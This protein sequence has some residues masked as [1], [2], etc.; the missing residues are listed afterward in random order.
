MNRSEQIDALSAALAKAQGEMEAAAKD[1]ENPYFHSNYA[2]LASV[3]AAIRKPLSANG[4]AVIQ[5][6]A[7]EGAKVTVTTI[8]VHS[9]GQW[10]SSDLTMTSKRQLKDGGGWETIDNPQAI[11]STVKYARR[12]ALESMVGVAA[13]D[14]DGEG[15]EGREPGQSDKPP[16]RRGPRA[17]HPPAETLPGCINEAQ[18]K[19][20]FALMHGAGRSQ[21]GVKA[22][23]AKHGFERTE[24]ITREKYDAICA[25]IQ[26]GN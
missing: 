20:I 21:A 5:P 11:G 25:E 19:R 16:A 13:E 23:I 4:L 7:V 14:D 22:I 24:Q 6:V 18:Q 8:L 10:I 2:D 3:W 9:S 17:T 15:A 12:Y 26:A 1:S